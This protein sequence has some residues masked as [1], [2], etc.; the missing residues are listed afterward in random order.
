MPLVAILLASASASA[1]LVG[2]SNTGLP[3]VSILAIVLMTEAYPENATCSVGAILPVLLV[4]DAFAVA[5]F[6]GN[7]VAVKATPASPPRVTGNGSRPVSRR[8]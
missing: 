2:L 7:A 1:L 5:W 8:L 6:R 4:G 3:G